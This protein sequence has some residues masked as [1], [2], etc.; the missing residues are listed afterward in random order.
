MEA[1]REKVLKTFHKYIAW[2]HDFTPKEL[3][4][5]SDDGDDLELVMVRSS[6]DE[7]MELLT[8]DERVAVAEADRAIAKTMLSETLAEFIEWYS[9]YP[10]AKWWGK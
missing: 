5:W 9:E 10:I 7:R 2:A 8:P 1:D 6:L 4:E 3:Q